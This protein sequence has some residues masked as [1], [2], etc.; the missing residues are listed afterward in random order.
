MDFAGALP[1]PRECPTPLALLPLLREHFPGEA[2]GL[3][4]AM[5]PPAPCGQGFSSRPELQEGRATTG[6]LHHVFLVPNPAP[7]T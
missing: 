1:L 2:P 4:S 7:G 3:P 6:F 5:F